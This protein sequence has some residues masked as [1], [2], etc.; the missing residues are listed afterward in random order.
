[1]MAIHSP[2]GTPGRMVV[3]PDGIALSLVEDVN[4]F[5]IGDEHLLGKLVRSVKEGIS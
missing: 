5:L 2:N 3:Y 1:V 4:L